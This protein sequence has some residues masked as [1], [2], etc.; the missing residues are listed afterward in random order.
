MENYPPG[1]SKSDYSNVEGMDYDHYCTCG[2]LKDC[3]DG[4][5]GKKACDCEEYEEDE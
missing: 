3:H 1:M 4:A 5:C 2:H